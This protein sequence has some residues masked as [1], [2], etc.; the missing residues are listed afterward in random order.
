MSVARNSR[1]DVK[2]THLLKSIHERLIQHGWAAPMNF[3]TV[4]AWSCYQGPFPRIAPRQKPKRKLR[5]DGLSVR[6]CDE[7]QPAMLHTTSS[8]SRFPSLYPGLSAVFSIY[9]ICSLDVCDST[10]SFIRQEDAARIITWRYCTCYG[11]N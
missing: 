10:L 4:P 6:Q 9:C 1:I 7:L 3:C 11:R 2:S 8:S 5:D